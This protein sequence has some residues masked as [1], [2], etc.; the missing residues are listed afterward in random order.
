[1]LSKVRS[2]YYLPG[3]FTLSW[4]SPSGE[5][6]LVRAKDN[7][8]D[9]S[10]TRAAYV[11]TICEDGIDEGGRSE[12]VGIPCSTVCGG[13]GSSGHEKLS[14]RVEF[15]AGATLVEAFYIANNQ[16]PTNRQVQFT[17]QQGVRHDT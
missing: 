4:F 2:E 12:I 3:S 15:I 11:K 8:R 10:Q 14:I 17:K 6:L 9:Q 13:T 7:N 1:M 5:P 16:F